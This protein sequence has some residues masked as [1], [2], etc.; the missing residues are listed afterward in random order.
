MKKEI[1]LLFSV[2]FA[3]QFVAAINLDIEK[4]SSNEALV[5]D[6]NVPATF[7]LEITNLG[8]TNDFEFYNLLGFSMFPVGTVH[9]NGGQTKE[10]R[11]EIS[12]IGE[13]DQRGSYTLQY[14]IRGNDKTEQEETVT[15][16]IIELKDAFEIGSNEINP[17]SDSIE[18]YIKNKYNLDFKNIDAE[19]SSAFFELNE[20]FDLGLLEQKKF[21]IELKDE[22]I[23]KLTAGFYTLNAEIKTEGK[24]ANVEGTIKFTEKTLVTS[25]SRDYGFFVNTK[26][27]KKTNEGNVI[28]ESETVIQKNIVSRLFTTFSPEPDTSE[29]KGSVVEYT[30]AREIKPGESLEIFVKT[31]WLFPLVV[32]LLIITST[33][34]IRRYANTKLVLKKKVTFV[35]AK[36]GE[37]AL[38]V[39]ILVHSKSYVERVNL[40]ERLPPLVKVHE[41]FG[42]EQPVRIDEKTRRIEWNFEKLEAGE[43]RM[44]SYIIYSKVGV[45][46]R[47][48]LPTATAIYDQEGKIKEVESNRAFFVAEEK[49]IKKNQW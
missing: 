9:I 41:R 7:D 40:V 12:P 24:T 35:Q 3:L 45:V 20:N 16:R 44:I 15:F 42:G 31:N 5:L 43:R 10:V 19:F 33:L 30:W 32:I 22:E 21:E 36:G 6:L 26:I 48:A 1:V 34:L 2:L 27:I 17:D 47:F 8:S 13:F 49:E 29:R 4:T 37:F 28:E 14:F 39:S 18:I 25:T 46:G 11:L 38:K 23:K